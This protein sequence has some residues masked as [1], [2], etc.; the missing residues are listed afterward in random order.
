L[1]SLGHEN[2]AG[3]VDILEEV[4]GVACEQSVGMCAVGRTIKEKMGPC[5][6]TREPCGQTRR[7]AS[8]EV[9]LGHISFIHDEEPWK[10]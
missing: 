7:L 10:W 1:P 4:K 8:L 6:M 9:N 3:N 5:R 2:W